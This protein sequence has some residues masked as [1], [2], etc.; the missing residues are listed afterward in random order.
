MGS[1]LKLRKRNRIIFDEKIVEITQED[2]GVSLNLNE[3][4]AVE[5]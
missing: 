3:G 4:E 2:S 1:G 5:N